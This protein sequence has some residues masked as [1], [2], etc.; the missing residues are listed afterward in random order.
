[1][2]GRCQGITLVELMIALFIA[3]LLSTMAIPSLRYFLNN[4]QLIAISNRVLAGIQF[5]RSIATQR[6]KIV[7]YCGSSNH[8]SCDGRWNKGQIVQV[9]NSGEVLMSY[10][11]L[12]RGY[13]LLWRS[14]FGR[15]HA[16]EFNADGFTRGQ[17]G[18]FYI[19]SNAHTDFSRGIVLSIALSGRV[20]R[21]TDLQR[22]KRYC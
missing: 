11:K 18:S 1:M 21:R 13:R 10:G 17:Q 12:P 9:I 14:S 2:Q 4:N 3:A 16:V 19:C 6:S 22:L 20:R 8:K 15:N 5:A 7:V